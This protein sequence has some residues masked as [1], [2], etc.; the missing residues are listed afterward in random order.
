MVMFFIIFSLTKSALKIVFL[1]V[2]VRV[3]LILIPLINILLTERSM[4]A[5]VKTNRGT[6]SLY[7]PSYHPIK[8]L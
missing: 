4:I 1:M 7:I 3:K 2:F 6:Q 8:F 5:L